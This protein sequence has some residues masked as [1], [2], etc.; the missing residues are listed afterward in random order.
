MA[1]SGTNTGGALSISTKGVLFLNNRRLKEDVVE[2]APQRRSYA[3]S[4]DGALNQ[5]WIIAIPMIAQGY[6]GRAR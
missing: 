2:L 3:V 1:Y 4:R 5:D 6:K